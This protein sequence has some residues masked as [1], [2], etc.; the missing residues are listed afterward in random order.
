M[1]L[2][3]NIYTEEG[4]AI[5]HLPLMETLAEQPG[6]LNITIGPLPQ[7][8]LY[9]QAASAVSGFF[10]DLTKGIGQGAANLTSPLIN[11]VIFILIIV[12]IGIF[13]LGKSKMLKLNL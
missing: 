9:D 1:D 6:F 3:D 11:Q 2:V 4:F 12:I 5:S 8:S 10:N 7:K 13:V